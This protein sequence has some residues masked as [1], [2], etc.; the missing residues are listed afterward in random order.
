[1]STCPAYSTMN[2]SDTTQYV[3]KCVFS[4]CGNITLAIIANGGCNDGIFVVMNDLIPNW[5]EHIMHLKC[6]LTVEKRR[7]F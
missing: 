3:G 2:T 4:V 6:W 7:K 1:M 5:K